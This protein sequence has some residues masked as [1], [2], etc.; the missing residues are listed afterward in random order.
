MVAGT[1][2]G[3]LVRGEPSRKGR[4]MPITLAPLYTLHAQLRPPITIA[5]PAGTRMIFEVD[6][7]EIAGEG[8]RGHLLGTAAADW[9]VVGPDGT[10]AIDV[11]ATV[12]L[13]DGAVIYLQAP[14]RVDFRDPDAWPKDIVLAPRDETAAPATSF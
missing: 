2:N 8:F 13:D 10:G 14:G 12:E 1:R 9:L 5:G 7:A 6:S 11:R 4:A 3:T